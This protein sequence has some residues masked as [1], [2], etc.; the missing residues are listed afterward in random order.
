MIVS[1]IQSVAAAANASANYQQ[2]ELVLSE[3]G[4]DLA[5]HASDPTYAAS[6]DPALHAASVI[7]L[8]AAA[9]LYRAHHAILWDFYP[10]D[11]VTLGLVDHAVTPKP[12]QRAYALLARAIPA[13]AVRIAPAESG[14][15]RLSG[16]GA[17]LATRD[18]AGKLRVLFV[19]RGG[20]G[21]WTQAVVG[22]TPR[23]PSALLMFS[24]PSGGIVQRSP[25]E[26]FYVAAQ[27]LVLAEF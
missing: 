16:S 12:L 19:N 3:W 23:I 20:A 11:L 5:A 6:I 9:G 1:A 15:G 26:T 4:P 2:L 17:V 25:S 13:D 10:N 22:G 18:A 27:S 24:D 21:K 14:D 8:G 7:A